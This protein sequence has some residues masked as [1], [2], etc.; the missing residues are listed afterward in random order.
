MGPAPTRTQDG[1][2][3]NFHKAAHQAQLLESAFS[4]A[5]YSGIEGEQLEDVLSV[6]V[7]FGAEGFE[8][9]WNP[10]GGGHQ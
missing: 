6:E 10:I 1:K 2:A 9:L 4:G 3:I 5:D 7:P 8:L